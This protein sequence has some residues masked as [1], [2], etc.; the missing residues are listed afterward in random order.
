MKGP[1]PTPIDKRVIFAATAYDGAL[2]KK[3]P[4]SRNEQKEAGL[5]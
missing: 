1:K 3:N 2:S 4:A 5:L